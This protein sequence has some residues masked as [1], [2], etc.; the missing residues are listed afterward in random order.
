[1]ECSIE[2]FLSLGKCIQYAVGAGGKSTSKSAA[3]KVS[4]W[5]AKTRSSQKLST[6][7][8]KCYERFGKLTRTLYSLA[9]WCK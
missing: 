8:A 5:V 1:M 2:A 4:F 7:E 6:L 3:L 9:L